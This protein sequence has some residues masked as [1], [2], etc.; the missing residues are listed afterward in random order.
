MAKSVPAVVS[1]F[2]MFWLAVVVGVAGCAASSS[3]EASVGLPVRP[4]V[5]E[6]DLRKLPASKTWKPGD[7]V[8]VIEQKQSGAGETPSP[9][10]IQGPVVGR[11]V[12]PSD[13][14]ADEE[15]LSATSSKHRVETQG[16]SFAVA[17]T[18]GRRLAGP[19]HLGSL[20]SA[21]GGACAAQD[22]EG[23][24]AARYDRRAG[25]WLL[26]RALESAPPRLCLAVS[27]TSDLLAGGWHLFDFETPVPL[28]PAGL[29]VRS[30][31]YEIPP[32]KGTGAGVFSLERA[33][34]L[35]GE[36]AAGRWTGG[37]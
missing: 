13:R 32:R 37:R 30:G 6:G 34:L 29:T 31:I 9:S 14:G 27:R 7:P 10:T 15:A 1:F 2:R 24:M 3:P 16:A 36:A 18:Q 17:D 20:W 8:R 11:A 23:A 26:I 21:P 5:F 12:T 35:A 33:R 19:A 22:G 4:E 28:D 25:R